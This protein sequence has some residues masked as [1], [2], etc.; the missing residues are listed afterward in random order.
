MPPQA[1]AAFTRP[2]SASSF[3]TLW[4]ACFKSALDAHGRATARDGTLVPPLTNDEA[5]RL[6]MAWRRAGAGYFPLWGQFAATAY[7]WSAD[8]GQMDLT[9]TQRDAMYP[10]QIGKEL[11]LALQSVAATLDDNAS[12]P[13]QRLEFD[14]GFDDVSVQGDVAAELKADGAGTV[15]FRLSKGATVP[16]KP[17]PKKQT[18]P[19]W[20]KIVIVY[21][22]YRVI[23]N[24]TGGPRYAG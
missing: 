12:G 21:F 24:I 4:G 3:G 9:P 2:M 18:V 17:D 23:K 10:V 20:M 15:T 19:G 22:G 16:P 13:S 14:R 8:N 5:M 7:G 6:I 1:R 11:W